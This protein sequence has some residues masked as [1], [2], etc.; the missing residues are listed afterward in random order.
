[1]HSI[2]S[3]SIIEQEDHSKLLLLHEVHTIA[4]ALLLQVHTNQQLIS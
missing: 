3:N 2:S 1:M 4:V